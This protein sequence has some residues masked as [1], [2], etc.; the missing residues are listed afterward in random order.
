MNRNEKNNN[1]WFH[2]FVCLHRKIKIIRT[3]LDRFQIEFGFGE[4]LIFICLAQIFCVQIGEFFFSL[5]D[6]VFTD[7]LE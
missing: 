5:N 1:H 6:F 3:H 4:Y 7:N 2:H